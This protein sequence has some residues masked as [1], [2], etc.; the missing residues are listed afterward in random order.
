ME[1]LIKNGADIN[2][3]NDEGLTAQDIANGWKP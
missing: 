3:K 1:F 2:A